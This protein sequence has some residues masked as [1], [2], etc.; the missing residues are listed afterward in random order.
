[1]LMVYYL[2]FGVETAPVLSIADVFYL[3]GYPPLFIALIS[4]LS[5]VK[6]AISKGILATACTTVF[7]GSVVSSFFFI[8]PAAIEDADVLAKIVNVAYP[9]LDL[10]LYMLSV[11]GL[12]VFKTTSLKGRVD[13]AWMLL[14][15]G[16]LMYALGDSWISYAIAKGTYYYGH[17]VE[18]FFQFGY[19]L[20]ILAFYIHAREL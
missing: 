8:I 20:L 15:V 5:L 7:A 16:F 3:I 9:M 12:L 1:M 13:K 14:N 17:P 19:L 11:L 6:P 4:Y 10:F 2:L 18:L